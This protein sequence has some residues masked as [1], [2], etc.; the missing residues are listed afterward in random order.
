[1]LSGIAVLVK[2]HIVFLLLGA[3]IAVLFHHRR[4]A[5]LRDGFG[6]VALTVLP[7]ATY[8]VTVTIAASGLEPGMT[9]SAPDGRISMAENAMRMLNLELLARPTFWRDWFLLAVDGTGYAALG[10]A[11]IGLAWLKPCAFKSMLVGMWISYPLFGFAFSN[12]ISDHGYYHAILIPLVALSMAPAAEVLWLRLKAGSLAQSA[13]IAVLLAIGLALGGLHSRQSL[14]A[15]NVEPRDVLQE[16]GA[17]VQHSTRT[18]YVA[19]HY[20]R[21]LEYWGEL[22]GIPWPTADDP[23]GLPARYR[24]SR[25]IEERLSTLTAPPEYFIITD[26]ARFERDHQDL[27]DHL[28]RNCREHARAAAYAIFSGCRPAGAI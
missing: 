12:R 4:C 27:K 2:P 6:F 9:L 3:G 5:R 22:S 1:L 10:A 11:F 14:R 24:G 23:Y 25:S 15:A 16:V 26:F 20:G 17:R 18:V 28:A 13:P 19:R 21:A 8:Y 7:A